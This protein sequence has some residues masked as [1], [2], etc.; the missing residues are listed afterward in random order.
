MQGCHGYGSLPAWLKCLRHLLIVHDAGLVTACLQACM[1]KKVCALPMHI[2]YP[3]AKC[4]SSYFDSKLQAQGARELLFRDGSYSEFLQRVFL[5][6]QR[7][8]SVGHTRGNIPRRQP[9]MTPTTQ[10]IVLYMRAIGRHFWPSLSLGIGS[11]NAAAT[12][13]MP[14]STGLA[15]KMPQTSPIMLPMP[16]ATIVDTPK[17]T[18]QVESM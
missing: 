10:P 14:T 13:D 11:R 3:S 2:L 8:I 9:E 18:P 12:A 4:C 7:R 6:S 16:Q 5:L 15:A 17:L 1:Q